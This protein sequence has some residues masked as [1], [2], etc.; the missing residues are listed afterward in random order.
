MGEQARNEFKDL[1]EIMNALNPDHVH[2]PLKAY[3]H[4]FSHYEMKQL[5]QNPRTKA[6]AHIYAVDKLKELY[7]D[8]LGEKKWKQKYYYFYY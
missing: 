7:K 5:R 2:E 3:C 1:D 6:E 8:V 4:Y